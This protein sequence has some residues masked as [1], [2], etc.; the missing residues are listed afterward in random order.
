MRNLRCLFLLIFL[1]GLLFTYKNSKAQYLNQN[2]DSWSLEIGNGIPFASFNEANQTEPIYNIGLIYNINSAFSIETSIKKG[3]FKNR[4]KLNY[5]GRTFDN[6]F[7]SF[8]ISPQMN[9]LSLLG[10]QKYIKKLNIYGFS[11]LGILHNNVKTAINPK[12][13]SDPNNVKGSI[14]KEFEGINNKTNTLFYSLGAGLKYN[15]LQSIGIFL[16]YQYNLTNSDYIDGYTTA[17]VKLV[18]PNNY[19]NDNYSLLTMGISIRLGSGHK[20]FNRSSNDG[21][22]GSLNASSADSLLFR[23]L[24]RLIQKN[25]QTIKETNDQLYTTNLIFRNFINRNSSNQLL[26]KNEKIKNLQSQIDSLKYKNAAKKLTKESYLKSNNKLPEYFIIA[27]AFLQLSK[28]RLLLKQ[29]KTIGFNDAQVIKDH[30]KMWYLV[31]Y[32]G[33]KNPNEAQKLLKKIKTYQNT[34]AWIYLTN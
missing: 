32:T 18:G 24:A 13:A 23:K 8:G 10:A 12:M 33:V 21:Y 30:T 7:T 26:V 28:A 15:F 31:A 22:F 2:V 1:G 34:S 4:N 11:G 3:I 19:S 16:R 29:L 17:H 20:L 27:D 5:F 14:I 9:I 25:G 6:H